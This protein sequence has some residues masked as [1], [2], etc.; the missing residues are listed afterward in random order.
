MK[1][2]LLVALVV[3]VGCTEKLQQLQVVRTVVVLT[4]APASSIDARMEHAARAELN[5]GLILEMNANLAR[6]AERRL[7]ERE[8]LELLIGSRLKLADAIQQQEALR[9]TAVASNEQY[10]ID[11][12]YGSPGM[13]P[14]VPKHKLQQELEA[15]QVHARAECARERV[16]QFWAARIPAPDPIEQKFV[17]RIVNR[18]LEMDRFSKTN[19]VFLNYFRV[20]MALAGELCRNR[21]AKAYK[22]DQSTRYQLEELGE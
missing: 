10:E 20:N 16:R 15:K 14:P 9:L 21:N 5:R 18:E 11:L 22:C 19:A 4:N 6:G 1:T 3:L 2:I 13:P 17:E 12:I 8:T 7:D